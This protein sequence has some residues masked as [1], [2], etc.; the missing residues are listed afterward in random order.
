MEMVVVV[1]RQGM[2]QRRREGRV[3]TRRTLCSLPQ[4]VRFCRQTGRSDDGCGN[5]LSDLQWTAMPLMAILLGKLINA[6]IQSDHGS[7]V[8]AVSNFCHASKKDNKETPMCCLACLDKPELPM[9]MLG[10]IA[11][12]IHGVHLHNCILSTTR[13]TSKGCQFLVPYICGYRNCLFSCFTYTD[14][15]FLESLVPNLSKEF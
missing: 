5:N 10:C 14:M 7:L 6:I 11:A 1:H 3:G 15:I 12:A 9:L 8:H 2:M 4:I 13:P